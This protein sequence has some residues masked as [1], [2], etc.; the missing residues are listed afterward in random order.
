MSIVGIAKAIWRR[1]PAILAGL[2]ATATFFFSTKYGSNSVPGSVQTLGSGVIFLIFTTL[3]Q[4]VTSAAGR[5][6]L[7]RTQ[8]N[9]PGLVA[10]VSELAKT[11]A[12]IASARGGPLG[13]LKQ[14]EAVVAK[15]RGQ[16][17]SD[18]VDAIARVHGVIRGSTAVAAPAVVE[19]AAAADAATP[20]PAP[21][22]G[23]EGAAADLG[24]LLGVAAPAA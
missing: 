14:L 23:I 15:H 10:D 17:E 1:E 7:T 9:L 3:R 16:I 12:P 5:D 20:V 18:V 8:T 2:L 19:P 11:L 21:A 24:S 22:P 6:L 4:F 13:Y